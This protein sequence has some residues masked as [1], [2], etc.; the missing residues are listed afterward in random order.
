M[1]LLADTG[2]IQPGTAVHYV[3]RIH[4]G[5]IQGSGDTGDEY[6]RGSCA[7]GG[8]HTAETVGMGMDGITEREDG[9]RIVPN[10]PG[11]EKETALG[12]PF[13]EPRVLRDDGRIG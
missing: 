2:A 12:K 13:L 4:I 9:D 6:L 8:H 3:R 1:H 5:G 7:H 11:A 10:V